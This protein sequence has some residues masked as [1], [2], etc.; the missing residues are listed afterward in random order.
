MG[1]EDKLIEKFHKLMEN[2]EENK[3]SLGIELIDGQLP[4]YATSGS[5][6]MDIYSAEEV[7][8]VNGIPSLIR[9]GFKLD[10]PQGYEVQIR[11]RSGL[12]LK[13]ITVVNSP[14]TIDSDYK[15]EVGIILKYD[16]VK[17]KKDGIGI[18]VYDIHKNDRIA[19][20]VL[21]KIPEINLVQTSVQDNERKGFGSTGI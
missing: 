19:Q 6:A 15:K 17:I 8:L 10:I 2:N 16:A 7:R 1:I 3:I 13:G 11:P 21:N 5:A 18:M 20:M 12:A 9:T 4:T 14:G